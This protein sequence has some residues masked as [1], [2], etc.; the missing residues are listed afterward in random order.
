M[1]T[2]IRLQMAVFEVFRG[3]W[4]GYAFWRQSIEGM[5]AFMKLLDEN[6][7]IVGIEFASI[8]RARGKDPAV[9][10]KE[11]VMADIR[12]AKWLHVLAPKA[13]SGRWCSF[14]NSQKFWEPHLTE[15]M[16]GARYLGIQQGW[17]MKRKDM[18]K[19]M[20]HDL[21]PRPGEK[22]KDGEENKEGMEIFWK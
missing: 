5:Q 19:S 18:A 22:R 21:A 17:H 11:E 20:C 10:T 14:E 8:C 2:S 16:C 15:R 3:P 13:C 9:S 4:G 1:W 7:P 12:D 6:D